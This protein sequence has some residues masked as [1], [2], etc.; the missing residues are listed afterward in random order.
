MPPPRE[1]LLRRSLARRNLKRYAQTQSFGRL[2]GNEGLEPRRRSR[3][4][5]ALPR[6]VLGLLLLG[7]FG[8]GLYFV[9]C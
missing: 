2:A 1:Q 9:F 4:L 5:C 6:L 3:A 7:F 8:I